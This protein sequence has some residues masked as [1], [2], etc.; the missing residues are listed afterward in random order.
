MSTSRWTLSVCAGVVLLL[1]ILA[2]CS[3]TNKT[4][5]DNSNGISAPVDQ[6]QNLDVA[7]LDYKPVLLLGGVNG[8]GILDPKCEYT[9]TVYYRDA[10]NN[11]VGLQGATVELKWVNYPWAYPCR[12]FCLPADDAKAQTGQISDFDPIEDYWEISNIT[13]AQGKA[14]FR[15][16]GYSTSTAGCPGECDETTHRRIHLVVTAPGGGEPVWHVGPFFATPR[17]SGVDGVTSADQSILL[18]DMY[19]GPASYHERS[20]LDGNGIVNGADLSIF[21]GIQFGQGSLAAPTACELP[22]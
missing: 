8:D 4:P 7:G 13:D 12:Q 2:G 22:Q 1:G 19:C 9:V 14:R 6:P 16:S 15:V 20:D 11:L 10:Q 18:G 21:L 5:T 3:R 17:L